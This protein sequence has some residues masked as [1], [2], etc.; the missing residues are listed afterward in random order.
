MACQSCYRLR[1]YIVFTLGSWRGFSI[2]TSPNPNLPGWNLE[3]KWGATVCTQ[4]RK[5]GEIAP[6]VLPKGA[7]TCSFCQTRP[8]GHLSCT[9]FNHFWNKRRESVSACIHRW[10]ILEFLCRWFSESKKQRSIA[11]MAQF[12]MMGII[13]RASRHPKDVP[14]VCEFWWVITVWTL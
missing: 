10:K 2:I 11:Q 8:F 4:T 3:Y 7:K 5:M 1:A 9:D 6:G 13:S 14:F 12:L